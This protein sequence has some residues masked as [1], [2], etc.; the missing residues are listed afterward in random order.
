[1][2]KPTKTFAPLPPNIIKQA[3]PRFIHDPQLIP[4]HFTQLLNNRGI[5]FEHSKATP[6][7]NL[8]SL[9]NQDHNP[10]CRECDNGFEYYDNRNITGVFSSNSLEKMFEV[11]GFWGISTAVI[12]FPAEYNDGTQA[13]FQYFDKLVLPSFTHRWWELI[14]YNFETGLDKLRYPAVTI[15]ILK[16]PDKT[17][18]EGTDFELTTNGFIEWLSIGETPTWNPDLNKGQIYSISYT[19]SPV[20]HVVQ[21]LHELRVSQSY[22]TNTNLKTAIR[23]PQQVV[24]KRDFLFSHPSDQDDKKKTIIPTNLIP[25]NTGT[26]V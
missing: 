11:Q 20:W 19:A 7:A 6:C 8:T 18:I 9:E 16:T 24:V 17:F 10:N 26:L 13:D 5:E 15:E 21:L 12:T 14:E 22:D 23:L 3:V 25:G 2:K 4:E 1:M